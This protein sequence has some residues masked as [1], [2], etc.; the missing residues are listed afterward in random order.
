MVM[1][2]NM[3]EIRTSRIKVVVNIP[4]KVRDEDY[5]V[6]GGEIN[7][8]NYK[9]QNEFGFNPND[10]DK[11]SVVDLNLAYV[12]KWNTEW[13]FVGVATPRWSSTSTTELNVKDLNLNLAA[14]VYRDRKDVEK[15]SRLV[16]GLLYNSS[17]SVRVPLPVLYYENR[18]HPKWSY[19]LGVPKSGLK[20]YTKKQHFFQFEII[21][22]GYYVNIQ[23][24]IVLMDDAA[25]T[26][27]SSTAVL[28]TLGYQYKFTKD[29]S[30]YATLG[31]TLLQDGL[32]RDENRDK[33]FTLNDG[34]SLYFRTGFRIGI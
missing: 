27:I 22:D 31:H 33:I 6:L 15:P 13:K 8:Y 16:L 9:I 18:F 21:L 11:F 19:V 30:V 28:A 12:L 25:A 23:D 29:I 5:L 10:L 7:S 2:Q 26:A 20:F 3:K 14:G 34:P 32:L 4:V 24:A 17:S 1:P